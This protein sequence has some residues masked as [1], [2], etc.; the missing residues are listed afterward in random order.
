[1]PWKLGFNFPPH[2]LLFSTYLKMGFQEENMLAWRDIFIYNKS[3]EQRDF[4]NQ[5]F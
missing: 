4:F 2:V 1:M 5:K 3:V